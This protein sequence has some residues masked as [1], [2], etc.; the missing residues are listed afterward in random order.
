MSSKI[1]SVCREYLECNVAIFEKK[2]VLG[3]ESVE[4]VKLLEK[5]IYSCQIA[6]IPLDR[7]CIFSNKISSL[8]G[9]YAWLGNVLPLCETRLGNSFS[10]VADTSWYNC[11]HTFRVYPTEN[12]RTYYWGGKWF[13]QPKSSGILSHHLVINYLPCHQWQFMPLWSHLQKSYHEHQQCSNI[14]LSNCPEWL[15]LE[16][17]SGI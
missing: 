7:P 10:L 17:I 4:P 1:W 16:P 5:M 6:S 15:S 2:G 8:L 14:F 13:L 3:T 12:I 9:F 11:P